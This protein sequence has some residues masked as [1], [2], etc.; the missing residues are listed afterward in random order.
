MSDIGSLFASEID[1]RAGR[2]G[3]TLTYLQPYL[4][5]DDWTLLNQDLCEL[6][7]RLADLI[8]SHHFYP[9]LR[10]FRYSERRYAMSRMLRFC[11]ET[12]SLL[13][14]MN[15]QHLHVP[16][17]NH[18][19]T[20][21]LWHASMQTLADAKKQFVI[22]RVSKDEVDL[23]L[24]ERFVNHVGLASSDSAALDSDAFASAYESQCRKCSNDLASLERC[25]L[26]AQ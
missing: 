2:S 17:V 16:S 6:S 14:A 26:T 7:S 13:R 23:T 4:A 10:Y 19:P 24:A 9:A 8:E 18:E 20:E 25:T 15:H 1:Y 3:D 21:R 5:S 12:A 11:L 22:C